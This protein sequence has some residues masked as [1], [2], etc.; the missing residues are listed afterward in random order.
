MLPLLYVVVFFVI[1]IFASR[2]VTEPARA[3]AA[4]AEQLADGGFEARAEV[5][6]SD[7]IGRLAERFNTMV[8]QLED[9]MRVRDA[10]AVAMEVQQHLLPA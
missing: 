8:P 3:L 9:R 5:T 2:A 1:A 7:E 10:L 6:G 4:A